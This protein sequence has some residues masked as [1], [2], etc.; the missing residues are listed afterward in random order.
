MVSKGGHRVQRLFRYEVRVTFFVGGG[1]VVQAL[2]KQLISVRRT[3]GST[4]P[5]VS[6]PGTAPS[7]KITVD[8]ATRVGSA[9]VAAPEV[10]GLKTVLVMVTLTLDSDNSVIVTRSQTGAVI[11]R[12]PPWR[13]GS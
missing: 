1:A 2:G 13:T 9:A 10:W 7:E 11:R 8:T 5:V 6:L 12:D 4:T 3:R